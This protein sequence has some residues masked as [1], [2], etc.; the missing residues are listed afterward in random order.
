M[1]FTG[2]GRL[3]LGAARRMGAPLPARLLSPD[4]RK[5]RVW[6]ETAASVFYVQGKDRE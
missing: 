6:M 2:S 1:V 4:P 3:P 5:E